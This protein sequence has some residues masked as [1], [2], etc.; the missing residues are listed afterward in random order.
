MESCVCSLAPGHIFL[1][2]G[3][4]FILHY[5]VRVITSLGKNKWDGNLLQY[6]TG[7]LSITSKIIGEHFP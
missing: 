1:D 3:S 4:G 5:I 2:V 6:E 7:V